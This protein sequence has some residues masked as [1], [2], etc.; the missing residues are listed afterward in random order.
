MKK[1]QLATQTERGRWWWVKDSPYNSELTQN[2]GEERRRQTLC[3][4]R[5]NIFVLKNFTFLLTDLF[6]KDQESS[7]LTEDHDKTLEQ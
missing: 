4:K 5:D 1:F 6:V 7:M 3:G 2:D